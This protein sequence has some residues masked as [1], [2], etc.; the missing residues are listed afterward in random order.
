MTRKTLIATAAAAALTLSSAWAQP[1]QGPG[2]N[3]QHPMKMQK[4]H[5]KKGK[6]SMRSIF[7]IQYGLPHY[8]KILMTMW[9]DPKLALTS[10][11]K[12]KLEAVR[13]RTLQQVKEIAPQVKKLTR[14]IVKGVKSGAKAESLSQKVD[15]LASLKAKATKIHLQCIEETRTILTPKQLEYVHEHLKQMRKKHRKHG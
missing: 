12:S 7:L 2:M 13:N 8:S 6:K 9:D 11:Q 5:A 15:T 3:G 10:E 4:K 14:E 1:G